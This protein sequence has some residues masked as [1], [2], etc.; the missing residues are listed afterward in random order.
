MFNTGGG[1]GV[2]EGR[3]RG[4]GER[5]MEKGR[6]VCMHIYVCV[7]MCV[8]VYVCMYVC[9]YV[10]P[11]SIFFLSLSFSHSVYVYIAIYEQCVCVCVYVCM[12]TLSQ[13]LSSLSILLYM[14]N[15]C[16]FVCMYVYV[17][18]YICM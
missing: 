18:M 11:L 7:C 2:R 10:Y 15:V 13:S 8:C 16:M 12:S 6:F 4:I 1:E 5:M 17:C 14:N 9:M 3:R